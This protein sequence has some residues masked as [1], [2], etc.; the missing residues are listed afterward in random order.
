MGFSNEWEKMYK[1]GT[2]NSIWPWSE[3]VSMFHHYFKRD[4]ANLN[5]LELGCGAG[6]NIPFFVSKGVHYYGLE[7]SRTQWEKLSRRFKGDDVEIAE[8]DFSQKIPFDVQ[9]DLILDRSSVT[10]NSTEG[11][12]NTVRLVSDQLKYGGYY[13]GIDWF[14]VHYDVFSDTSLK[15]EVV[16]Q[17]TKIF[18]SGCLADLGNVHFSDEGHIRELFKGMELVELY[19]KVETWN[20]PDKK[21]IARWCFVARKVRGRGDG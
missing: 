5:V 2:H 18:H 17:N 12:K 10:H 1:T 14:S 15:Y 8:G 7:G 13:F 3:V 4:M 11:I 6:A 16:D 21:R 9:F 20:I 19:E